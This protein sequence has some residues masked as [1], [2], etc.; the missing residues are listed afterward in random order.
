MKRKTRLLGLALLLLLVGVAATCSTI[1]KG[2]RYYIAKCYY[3]APVK[4]TE[5]PQHFF[6]INIDEYST[7]LESLSS[8]LESRVVSE[9]EYQGRSL[10]IHL[11]ELKNP[12]ANK[13]LMVIAGV[14]GNESGGTL[15][16]LE[17]LHDIRTNRAF[18]DEWNIAILSPV[19]PVGLIERSRYDQ[20]GCDL[21]RKIRS[22]SQHGIV[23]QRTQIEAFRPDFVVS[24]HEAPSEGF[25][26]H[27]GPHLGESLAQ[28]I[29]TDLESQG[30]TLA[31]IDYLGRNLQS[32]G[33][34]KVSGLLKIAKHLVRVESL[35][36]YL[37]DKG[38]IEITTES[39]WNNA[40]TFQRVNSHVLLIRSVVSNTRN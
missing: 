30:I 10:P 34:S 5:F 29:L 13:R 31:T 17:L 7:Q 24:M 36:D 8:G 15:A 27:P 16:I 3:G 14:H 38:I 9:V 28:T 19:N 22:S 33:Q 21:N 20:D 11:V 1:G 37:A 23:V 4:Q 18:Y 2:Y 35:G 12:D 32:K 26:I 6:D 25:L 40:D 39:G